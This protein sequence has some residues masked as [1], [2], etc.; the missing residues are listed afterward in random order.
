MINV[1]ELLEQIK[2]SPYEEITVR[3]Q[4]TGTVEFVVTEPGTGV[5]GPQG[6]WQEKP[7]TLLARIE[8]ERNVTPIHAFQKGE[9]VSL[10]SELE[11]AFVQ[12]GTPL[13]TIRHLLTRDEVLQLILRKAL[14][15]FR[16]PERATYYFIPEIDKKIQSKGAR[17]VRVSEGKEVF[18]LSRMKRESLLS[19]SGPSGL[20]YTVYFKTNQNVDQGEPLIGVCP[21]DQLDTIQGVVNRVHSEWEEK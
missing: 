10:E 4:H 3:A 15:L 21:E 8:R 18:I 13:L 20:V 5:R 11:G 7:G 16:A 17:S 1:K 19:Y 12:A 14:Y 2:A 9:V 6:T